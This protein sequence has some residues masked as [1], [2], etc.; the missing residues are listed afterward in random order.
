MQ[1]VNED[2]ADTK[3]DTKR[4]WIDPEFEIL[5][6]REARADLMM[7]NPEGSFYS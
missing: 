3:T 1:R 6:A 7:S 4:S 5:E 2:K